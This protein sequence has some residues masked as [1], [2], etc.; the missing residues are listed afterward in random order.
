MSCVR[1]FLVALLHSELQ[2]FFGSIHPS[3]SALFIY[4]LSTKFNSLKRIEIAFLSMIQSEQWK[5]LKRV[6]GCVQEPFQ[7]EVCAETL[8]IMD[9]VHFS[10]C[11]WRPSVIQ[12]QHSDCVLWSCVQHAH[13]SRGEVIG[14]L[15]GHFNGD[16]KILKVCEVEHIIVYILQK[17]CVVFFFFSFS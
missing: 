2:Y 14:L 6:F 9:M 4:F 11:A 7:V 13:V 1:T 16:A 3:S 12:Q 5:R 8:L 17:W 15:G 10:S